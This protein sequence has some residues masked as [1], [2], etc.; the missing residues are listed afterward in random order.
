MPHA[1]WAPPGWYMLWV[2]EKGTIGGSPTLIPSE[3]CWV[4]LQ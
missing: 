2:I 3:A 1:S 4:Q